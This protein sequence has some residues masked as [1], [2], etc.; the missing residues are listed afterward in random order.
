MCMLPSKE[1]A[2]ETRVER[3]RARHWLV[4]ARH[5]AA[6]AQGFDSNV[7]SIT[8]VTIGSEC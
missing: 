1:E 7:D 8:F 6:R 3:R 2:V 4:R 5:D